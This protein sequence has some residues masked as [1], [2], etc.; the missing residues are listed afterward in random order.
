MGRRVAAAIAALLLF[1]A[2]A[3]ALLEFRPWYAGTRLP[4]DLGDPVLVLYLLEWGGK[5]I[6]EGLDGFWDAG[7]YFPATRVLTLSDHLL[8]PAAQAK[9]FRLLWDDGVAAYNFLSWAYLPLARIV[10]GLLSMRV[11]TRVYPFVSL[12][13]VVLA[14]RGIDVDHVLG[15]GV[16][17]VGAHPGLLRKPRAR[18]QRHFSR[19]PAPR[20]RLVA[21]A[22][23]TA[24]RAP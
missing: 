10:P 5:S 13:L 4:S 3:G 8:G 9:V 19:G 11:P 16:T 18:R 20:L 1:V 15:L 23:T 21:G 2:L 22:T 6:G 12:A 14:A 7:F 24:P 17:H